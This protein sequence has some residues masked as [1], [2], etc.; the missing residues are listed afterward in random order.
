MGKPDMEETE[1]RKWTDKYNTVRKFRGQGWTSRVCGPGEWW[2]FK[3]AKD[4]D[5]WVEE[6]R[7]TPATG[8]AAEERAEAARKAA[9]EAAKAAEAARLK[10]EE[11]ASRLKAEA[12]A[13]AKAEAEAQAERE[14]EEREDPGQAGSEPEGADKWSLVCRKADRVDSAGA[15]DL[16]KFMALLANHH[17]K[18]VRERPMSCLRAIDTT[19]LPGDHAKDLRKLNRTCARDEEFEWAHLIKERL[20]SALDGVAREEFEEAS[21]LFVH[22]A[23]LAFRAWLWCQD[24]RPSEP[25]V[26]PEE[27]GQE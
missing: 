19:Y 10:A 25:A 7:Q 22:T 14:V 4:A 5:R 8:K 12:E 20:L 3:N 15:F 21:E 6:H 13:E 27:D 24:Q 16:A 17:E 26:P 1:Y 18:M 9:E 11:E 2:L 23:Q